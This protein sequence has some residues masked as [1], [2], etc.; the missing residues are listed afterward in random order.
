LVYTYLT[1]DTAVIDTAIE[2]TKEAIKKAR[3]EKKATEETK[4]NELLMRLIL[5]GQ[6]MDSPSKG[7]LAGG[8]Y[9]TND[10]P[11]YITP[12]A[13]PLDTWIDAV[14]RSTDEA[15]LRRALRGMNGL[16]LAPKR[17]LVVQWAEYDWRVLEVKNNQ[18]LLLSEWL[19]PDPKEFNPEGTEESKRN[20]WKYS[21]LR[22]YLNGEFYGK[23]SKTNIA[24][25]EVVTKGR[26][27]KTTD[28]A[29]K[30]YIFLLSS[31][32]LVRYFSNHAY[33]INADGS[34]DNGQWS[35]SDEDDAM[36]EARVKGS[37]QT[38]WWW[39][40]SPGYGQGDA[41]YVDNGGTVD[42]NGNGVGT[43]TGGVRPALWLNL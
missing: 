30:D 42:L 14:N 41:A 11:K 7:G 20:K 38:S 33:Q 27:I 40:R 28:E 6:L 25:T 37:E 18:A 32:E 24:H 22:E 1:A 3:D 19:L 13:N 12:D 16:P 23:L 15:S 4:Q 31:E 29:T 39:L 17:K 36:R 2:A 43:E 8:P 21:A 5:L 10:Y 9:I 34:R 26:G 35:I